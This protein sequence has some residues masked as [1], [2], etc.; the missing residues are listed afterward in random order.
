MRTTTRKTRPCKWCNG[1]GEIENAAYRG[2]EMRR[3][4]EAADRTLREVAR[5][6]EL[7]AAYISDLELGRRAWSQRLITAY[8][9]ALR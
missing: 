5:R 8:Q 2:Q 7:S 9:K 4:R 6:M 1:T 3:K